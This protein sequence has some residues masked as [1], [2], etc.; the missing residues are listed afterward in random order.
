MTPARNVGS[1]RALLA[2]SLAACALTLGAPEAAAQVAVGPQANVGTETDFGIGGRI[3]GNIRDA[4]LEAVGSFDVYFPDDP[5]DFWELNGNLFYH[6]HLRETDAVLPYA[7]G[8][9][10]ISHFS[11]GEGET[12]A[13]LNLAGGLRF[14]TRSDAS[15]FVELRGVIGDFDQ[16]VV[17]LGVLFGNAAP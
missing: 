3:V 15:P 4:N 16:L 11:N 9:L 17:T 14:A 13:G 1:K 8:G 2:S 6:F 12:E 10:N 7:G 5:V